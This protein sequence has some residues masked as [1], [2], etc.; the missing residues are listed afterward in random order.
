MLLDLLTRTGCPPEQALMVGDTEYDLEMARRAGVD[1]VGVTWGAHPAERLL[2]CRP[3]AC[4]DDLRELAAWLS[5]DRRR[6]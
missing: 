1:A 4:L 6:A 3:A 2:A 5:P